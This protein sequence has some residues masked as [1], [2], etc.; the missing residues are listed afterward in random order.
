MGFKWVVDFNGIPGAVRAPPSPPPPP[1]APAP[2]A[3]APA[4]ACELQPPRPSPRSP[5][6]LRPPALPTVRRRPH[7]RSQNHWV[8]PADGFDI[9]TVVDLFDTWGWVV[10][11]YD[12]VEEA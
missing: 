5:R 10:T 8:R 3:R 6:L 11:V 7:P 12:G 1:P 2:A 4:L 9:Q